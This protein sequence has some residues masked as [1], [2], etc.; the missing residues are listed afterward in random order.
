MTDPGAKQSLFLGSLHVEQDR[1][2]ASS[3]KN[4]VRL[5]VPVGWGQGLEVLAL[6]VLIFLETQ[7]HHCFR[8]VR[9]HKLAQYFLVKFLFHLS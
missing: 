4:G 9:F 3:L 7:L 6:L 8:Y 5:M 1:S 2:W